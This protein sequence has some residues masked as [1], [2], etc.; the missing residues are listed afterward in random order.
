MERQQYVE[1]ILSHFG[2]GHTPSILKVLRRVVES[3]VDHQIRLGSK[4]V[5]LSSL[6]ALSSDWSKVVADLNRVLGLAINL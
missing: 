3:E 5:V 1:A 6:S 4:D 2:E